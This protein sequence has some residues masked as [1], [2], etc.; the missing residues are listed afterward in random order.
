MQ[1]RTHAHTGINMYMYPW[2]SKTATQAGISQKIEHMFERTVPRSIAP[3][4][5]NIYAL[6]NTGVRL[7]WRLTSSPTLC[8]LQTIERL[9]TGRIQA[10][11]NRPL[12]LQQILG[13]RLFLET[14]LQWGAQYFQQNHCWHFLDFII[15]FQLFFCPCLSARVRAWTRV[16]ICIPWIKKEWSRQE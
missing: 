8:M 13:T 2:C 3:I 14:Y 9:S 4:S 15:L 11:N 16:H 5:E 10:L 12:S 7:S 6:I 1:T